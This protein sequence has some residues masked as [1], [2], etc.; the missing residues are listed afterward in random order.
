MT[1]NINYKKNKSEEECKLQLIWQYEKKW[2][3]YVN[4]K[5]SHGNL[6]I[7]HVSLFTNITESLTAFILHV[8]I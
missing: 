4:L 1:L 3:K 5:E 6:K 7:K 2:K 8:D